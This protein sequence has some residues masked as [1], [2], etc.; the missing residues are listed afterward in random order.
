MS[1]I[2]SDK[3]DYGFAIFLLKLLDVVLYNDKD[4]V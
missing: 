3:Y 4:F 2:N 1:Y